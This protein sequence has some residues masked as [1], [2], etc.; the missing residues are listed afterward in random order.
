MIAFSSL[1]SAG[2]I[3]RILPP[4]A[5]HH[6]S[7]AQT[8]S[9]S[10]SVTLSC[11]PPAQN[12]LRLSS[13]HLFQSSGTCLSRNS[14]TTPSRLDTSLC[15]SCLSFASSSIAPVKNKGSLSCQRKKASA[16]SWSIVSSVRSCHTFLVCLTSPVSIGQK[17]RFP[18]VS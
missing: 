13:G 18:V 11:T 17:R 5:S 14:R 2:F 15:S 10:T 3:S 4:R 12:I 8:L 1:V 9:R 6:T 16:H 7:N